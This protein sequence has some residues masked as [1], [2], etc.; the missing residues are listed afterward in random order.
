MNDDLVKKVKEN[1]IKNKLISKNDKI[2]LM[3]SGGGDSVG[4]FYVLNELKEEMEFEISLLHLNHKIREQADK[5]AMLVKNIAKKE[6]VKLFYFEEDITKKAREEKLTLEEAGREVRYNF[7]FNVLEKEHFDKIATA[8]HITDNAES[9]LLN[10][11]RGSGIKGTCSI[12]N[13]NEKIIRPFINIEKEEILSFLDKRNIEYATDLTNFD[14]NYTRNFIRCEIL[15]KLNEVN[16]QASKHLLNFSRT[17][18]MVYELI[19]SLAN[20]VS[21]KINNNEISAKIS[22]IEDKKDIVKIQIIFNMMEKAGIKKDINYNQIENILNLLE[23]KTTFDINL[24]DGYVIKR[25]YDLLSVSK[26]KKDE[27]EVFLYTVDIKN[28]KE[29]EEFIIEN[30]LFILKFLKINK[31]NFKKCNVKYVDCGKIQGNII[32]R[33]RLTG[34]KFSPFGLKGEKTIKKY[35]IDKKI[36]KEK[37]NKIPLVLSGKDI[38]YVGGEEISE[39]Y[40]AD[41]STKQILLINF[42]EKE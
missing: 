16:N 11:I 9:I 35:F 23:I 22:Q 8:H 28:L 40:K 25:R 38:V 36:P 33:N 15:P 34:D 14:T 17:Q 18:S 19:K 29:N 13:K 37:R 3:I 12:E 24:P 20:E 5:D 6:N 41:E 30:E 21:L 31:N 27:N 10:L 1:I 7:A 26:I 42:I 39:K 32:I 4:L 2:L